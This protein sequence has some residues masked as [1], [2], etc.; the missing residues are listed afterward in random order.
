MHLAYLE[1]RLGIAKF[2]LEF[3]EAVMSFR[4]GMSDADMI[5][6]RYFL[7]SPKGKRCLIEA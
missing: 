7:T 3:P 4:D 5:P 1:L 6:E 2:F